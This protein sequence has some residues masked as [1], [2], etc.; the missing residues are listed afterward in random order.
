MNLQRID[1]LTDQ[2][3][4][5]F[6]EAHPDAGIFHTTRWLEALSRTYNYKPITY[7]AADQ[8]RFISGI[9]FC[10]VKSFITGG[11]LVSLPF[12]D[13]CQ[14]LIAHAGHLKELMAVVQDDARRD[15]YRYVEIRPLVLNESDTA[16]PKSDSVMVHKLDIS[17]SQEQLLQSFHADCIRRKIA[18][19]E[20]QQLRYEEGRS[21]ELLRK[22]YALLLLTR[23]R[24]GLPPQPFKWF[25]NIVSC[26]GDR[27]K[28]RVVSRDETPI[29]SIITLSF[30]KTMVYKYG[31]SDPQYNALAGSIFLLWRAIQQAKTEG[32]TEL[33]LGRSD[34]TTPGLITFKDRWGAVRIPVNYYRSGEP[35]AVQSAESCIVAMGKRLM[36]SVPD[37]ML[38]A[39]GGLL[40][41]HVG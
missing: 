12:S 38:S 17:R 26:L 22:F 5:T 20:R 16:F 7:V 15:G 36:T 4:E 23:R 39:L 18:K 10:N 35:A 8:G 19:S 1:P 29:A 30:K 32:L 24:H 9:P 37:P 11:R 41:R 34:Y 14:P 31:C 33:D 6:V 27:L 13:H 21:E 28:I 2:R 3:W 40:Y 25:Q